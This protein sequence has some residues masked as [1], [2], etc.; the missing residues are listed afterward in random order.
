VGCGAPGAPAASKRLTTT[1]G[2]YAFEPP[3]T[4]VAALRCQAQMH[5]AKSRSTF[6]LVGIKHGAARCFAAPL[7]VKPLPSAS[8]S[9]GWIMALIAIACPNCSH[10]GAVAAESLPRTLL[11]IVC[12]QAHTFECVRP[13]F[14]QTGQVT[15]QHRTRGQRIIALMAAARREAQTDT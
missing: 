8:S 13:L 15:S 6:V 5:K 12:G 11:C 14:T 10:R 3:R 1:T 4:A 7:P 2:A 9:E